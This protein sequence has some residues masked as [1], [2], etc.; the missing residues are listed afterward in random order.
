MQSV[1][2]SNPIEFISKTGND[3]F[4]DNILPKVLVAYRT[5]GDI[6]KMERMLPLPKSKEEPLSLLCPT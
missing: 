1:D 2:V 6:V 4:R 5:R 3:T